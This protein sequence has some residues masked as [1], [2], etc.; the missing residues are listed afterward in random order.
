MQRSCEAE[1]VTIRSPSHE[2]KARIIGGVLL[3]LLLFSLGIGC[4][5]RSF[6]HDE[7][8]FVASGAL[9]A[10]EG[11]LPYIDYPYFHLPNLVFVYAA[12]FSTNN[13]LLLTARSFNICCAWLLLVLIYGMTAS[14]FRFLR[15]KRWIIAAAIA[16]FLACHQLFRFTAGRAWN[17]DLPMLASVAALVAFFQ[18]LK[19]NGRRGWMTA[20]GALLG[21][22]AGTRLTFLPLV[23][24]FLVL[25]LMFRRPNA[26]F[27]G[28]IIF[29]VAFTLAM[30]PTLVLFATAPRVFLFDNLTCNGTLNLRFRELKNPDGMIASKLLFPFK[31]LKSPATL[32]LVAS[33]GFFGCWCPLRKGWRNA[34]R[35]P[36]I[37]AWLLLVPF[38]LL[39]AFLPTPSYRQYY[40]EPVPFL[41]LG[42]T[43][44]IARFWNRSA[45]QVKIFR[46]LAAVLVVSLLELLPALWR[47]NVFAG[48]DR[49]PVWSI[50]RVGLEMRNRARPGPVLTLSPIYPLEGGATIY[51]QFCTGPFAWRIAP[52]VPGEDKRRY[53]LVDRRELEAFFLERP[54][55]ILTGYDSGTLEQPLKDYA[56]ENHYLMTVLS[57][58]EGEL[59]SR[60]D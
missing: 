5:S 6:N 12:L 19:P 58:R 42:A 14:A 47:A 17:H 2:W 53:G 13:F 28:T 10:R 44:G 18:A 56:R 54:A 40:Y 8:Q 41:L 15:E 21:L 26:R 37:S 59:W 43:Y 48:I 23:V 60:S 33:F 22:A 11:L 32:L 3:A 50:H 20:S 38:A 25:T 30:L 55:A 24:P 36:E 1:E 27:R 34:F 31:Q 7:G 49:W 39:G 4:L 46:T 57:D 9:L 52:F 35:S 51:P 45:D 29:L 16:L